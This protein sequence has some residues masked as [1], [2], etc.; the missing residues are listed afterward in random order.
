MRTYTALV[1]NVQGIMTLHDL[2][3]AITGILFSSSYP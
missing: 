3:E 2:M 1:G